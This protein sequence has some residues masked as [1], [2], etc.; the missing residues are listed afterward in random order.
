MEVLFL[1]IPLSLLL[2][3]VFLVL[4][5]KNAKNGQFDEI[6]SH[7]TKIFDVTYIKDRK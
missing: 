6:E 7:K 4:F 5:I 3:L 1:T 2:A